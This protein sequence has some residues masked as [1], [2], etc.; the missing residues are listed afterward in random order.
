MIGFVVLELS[1]SLQILV[2]RLISSVRSARILYYFIVIF[3]KNLRSI[4][5]NLLIDND[6]NV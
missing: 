2:V 4:I 1:V 5:T 3:F 6:K